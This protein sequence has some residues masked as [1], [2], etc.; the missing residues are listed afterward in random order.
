MKK[1]TFFGRF[2]LL[3][4]FLFISSAILAGNII[5]KEN[6]TNNFAMK[7]NTYSVIR[8]TNSVAEM[9]FMSVKTKVGNFTLFTIPEYGYTMT[10]GEPK[11]PVMKKL[12]EVP[13]NATA[14]ISILNQEFIELN[15]NDLG[16]TEWVMPAQPSLSKSIENPDDVDFIFNQNSYQLDAYLGQELVKVVDMGMMRGVRIA[17]LEIA[18]VLYNPVQNTIKVFTSIEIKVNFT[19]ANLQMTLDSK[20]NLFSPYFEGIYSQLIN[21]KDH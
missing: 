4:S 21:Y 14:E 19:G 12:I 9:D 7:E 18:P 17:G 10:E 20:Q 16:I 11:L 15:L 3:V 13:L 6:G 5:V 1:T 8:L 2:Q